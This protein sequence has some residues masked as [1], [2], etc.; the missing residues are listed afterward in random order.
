MFLVDH[1]LLIQI[2]LILGDTK[3]RSLKWLFLHENILL[4]N[5]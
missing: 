5:S 2:Y 1:M 4:K 3:R